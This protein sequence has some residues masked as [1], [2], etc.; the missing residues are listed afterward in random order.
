MSNNGLN[1]EKA[2][3]EAMK[4]ISK[5]LE[6]A[7]GE[8]VAASIRGHRMISTLSPEQRSDLFASINDDERVRMII[9]YDEALSDLARH[10]SREEGFTDTDFEKTLAMVSEQ[11]ALGS[12]DQWREVADLAVDAVASD[13]EMGKTDGA[14]ARE[15]ARHFANY[16]EHLDTVFEGRKL[17]ALQMREDTAERADLIWRF[18]VMRAHG[19]RRDEMREA[20][21]EANDQ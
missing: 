13:L 2:I 21:I 7:P 15:L 16:P 4:H 5:A 14:P 8:S 9:Q 11:A 19:R 17:K 1:S 6:L 12:K 20:L 3:R 18:L 10:V